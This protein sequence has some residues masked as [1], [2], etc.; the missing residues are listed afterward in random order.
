MPP[1]PVLDLFGV[2]A[3]RPA[4]LPAMDMYAR[5]QVMTPGWF[6]EWWV[7]RILPNLGARDVVIEP[8]AGTGSVLA[9]IPSEVQAFGVEIDARLAA[10]AAERTR[11]RVIVGDI[12]SVALDVQPSCAITNPP[13]Q[14][15]F[16]REL[17]DRMHGILPEHG[18]VS[19]LVPVSLFNH[20]RPTAELS[21]RWS[22][23]VELVPRDLF[24]RLS[25][26]ICLVQFRRSSERVM[27]GFAGYHELLAVRALP[28]ETQAILADAPDGAWRTVVARALA[29]LGGEATLDQIYA[30][31][32]GHRRTQGRPFWRDRVRAICGERFTRVGV[33]RFRLAA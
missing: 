10:V 22:M 33:G 23:H 21:T 14:A 12:R 13:F 8:C 31:I 16:I 18:L 6:S 3:H 7:E 26:P 5:G 24:G 17:L 32:E 4:V 25:L 20:A 30:A 2:A 28:R 9:A 29:A 11:R 19:L 27:V 15:R 1:P